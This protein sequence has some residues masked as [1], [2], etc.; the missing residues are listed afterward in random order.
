[1]CKHTVHFDDATIGKCMLRF[2][3]DGFLFLGKW[4]ASHVLSSS[5]LFWSCTGCGIITWTK[6]LTLIALNGQVLGHVL[7][8][9]GR[10]AATNLAM[11]CSCAFRAGFMPR[12]IIV[13]EVFDDDTAAASADVHEA[14]VAR[15]RIKE[16]GLTALSCHQPN[17]EELFEPEISWNSIPQERTSGLRRRFRRFD[18]FCQLLRLRRSL[19]VGHHLISEGLHSWAFRLH[20]ISQVRFGVLRIPEE[21]EHQHACMYGLE[22][23]AVLLPY[24]DCE[25]PYS[26]RSSEK[27]FNLALD[28]DQR[29]LRVFGLFADGR[30]PLLLH[31]IANLPCGSYKL[32]VE[33]V[34]IRF[35]AG[36]V[37]LLRQKDHPS[38]CAGC[39]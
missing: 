39:R 33:F 23:T 13:T 17:Y 26:N 3:E 11:A 7:R 28:M 36:S 32:V 10:T 15:A 25:H 9:A 1:M 30:K 20:A 5:E 4:S 38:I 8:F 29:D 27:Y 35:S 31:S 34:P 37:K 24:I 22:S 16:A 6:E 19:A 21:H 12:P 18:A 2:S 14:L